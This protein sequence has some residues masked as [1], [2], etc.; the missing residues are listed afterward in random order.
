M[1]ASICSGFCFLA[2]TSIFCL[3]LDS[4]SKIENIS[5]RTS[6]PKSLSSERNF[7]LDLSENNCSQ[8]DCKCESEQMQKWNQKCP[9]FSP[10]IFRL[11]A[12]RFEA[13]RSC[14]VPSSWFTWIQP[15]TFRYVCIM[16]RL[17]D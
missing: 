5:N 13:R 10:A 11:P 14:H 15:K 12:R 1:I 6:L 4:L 7:I 16:Y 2:V 8:D 9:V 3:C 17:N